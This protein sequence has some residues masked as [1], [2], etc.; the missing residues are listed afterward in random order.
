MPHFIHQLSSDCRIEIHRL[1]EFKSA[2]LPSESGTQLVDDR[3]IIQSGP[4]RQCETHTPCSTAK[5]Q[6]FRVNLT[7]IFFGGKLAVGQC[8]AR[9]ENITCSLVPSH[10]GISTISALPDKSGGV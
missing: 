3:Q 9:N 7:E 4:N 2:H 1:E 6:Y 10:L 8:G 5:I